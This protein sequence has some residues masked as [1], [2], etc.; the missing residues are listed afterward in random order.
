MTLVLG[1]HWACLTQNIRGCGS[2]PQSTPLPLFNSSYRYHHRH[3]HQ[4]RHHNCYCYPLPYPAPYCLSFYDL[5]SILHQSY[6]CHSVQCNRYWLSSFYIRKIKTF[7]R[8]ST[9]QFIPILAKA[10]RFL[11]ADPT[12]Q[13]VM[14]DCF[15][16]GQDQVNLASLVC[17]FEFECN[18]I[19]VL[20]LSFCIKEFGKYTSISNYRDDIYSLSLDET[21]FK[22]ELKCLIF[23]NLF[24]WYFIV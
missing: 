1:G 22:E 23:F 18:S 14:L 4:Q 13:D 3:R 16:V 24:T 8:K 6:H 11:I 5:L 7:Q 2:I 19:W 20:S 9:F 15:N 12:Q 17:L 10:V 21:T